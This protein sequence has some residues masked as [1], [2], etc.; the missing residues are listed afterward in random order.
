MENEKIEKEKAWGLLGKIQ[1]DLIDRKKSIASERA[2]FE[3][4]LKQLMS[5]TR[6]YV[7]LSYEDSNEKKFLNDKIKYL[8]GCEAK[9]QQEIDAIIY[10]RN[11]MKSH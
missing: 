5:R 1:L 3:N 9:I 2:R 7:R 10:A 6:P 8:K 4:K 11:F